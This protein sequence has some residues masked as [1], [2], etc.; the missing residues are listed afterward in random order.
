MFRIGGLQRRANARMASSMGGSSSGGFTG[1]S[2]G[3]GSGGTPG[4]GRGGTTT[5]YN[6]VYDDLSEGSIIEYFL[7]VDPRRLHRIWRRIYLQDAIAGP[8]IDLIGE[9]GWSNWEITG[10]QDP[11]IRK[12]YEDCYNAIGA[13]A[14]MPELTKEFLVMGKYIAHLLYD[15][16]KGY[17]TR[18]I[19]QD[20]D[21]LNITKS[22]VAGFPPKIDLIPTPEMR[23]WVTSQDPRD[24]EARDQ[25]GDYAEFLSTG[26]T[27]PLDPA[28]TIYVCR[29][30]APYD[31]IGAS[32][33][34]RIITFVAYEK[35]LVNS[36]IAAA[37]R[38]A[39][40]IRHLVAGID[41]Q[42]GWEPSPEELDS[43]ANLFMRADEDPVGA[44]VVTRTG[45]SV[46]EVGGNSPQDMVKISDE[47]GFISSGKMNALGVSEQFLSGE[48]TYCLSGDTLVPTVERGLVRIDELASKEAGAEQS[49]D[50]TVDSRWGHAKPKTWLYNGTKPTI[51]V[52]T[53]FGNS[54]TG[55]APHK[56]LVF[57]EGDLIWK[58]TKDLQIGDYLC[59]ST[60]KTVRTTP[61]QLSLGDIPHVV[62]PHGIAKTVTKPT[63][64]T[65]D[66]AFAM[67]LIV[68]EGWLDST[69]RISV[70]NA[71]TA[72]LDKYEQILQSTFGLDSRR[73]VVA[74]AGT[75]RVV[76]GVAYN[77]NKTC[78]TSYASSIRVHKW[79]LELGVS[80]EKSQKKEIP[81]SILQADEQSQL[82]FLAAFLEGDGSIAKN[83]GE[84]LF[85]S[86]SKKILA[87]IQSMLNAHGFV[88]NN[89][90]VKTV[91][92][93]KKDSYE[94]YDRLKPYMVT[95]TQPRFNVK[96]RNKFGVPNEW[97]KA[98][99]SERKQF[100][101]RHGIV[102]R[103]DAGEDTQ[104][105]GWQFPHAEK[106]FL[107]DRLDAG[108]Y[109]F[110]DQLKEISK[111]THEKLV[112]LF[113]LRYNFAR[114]TK[115]EEGPVTD[116]YDLSMEDTENRSFVANGLI[117]S[118]STMEQLMSV[119][120]EKIR[121]LRAG[122]TVW[123]LDEVAKR[124]A[125]KNE[126]VKRTP[127]QLKH[128]IRIKK[129]AWELDDSELILPTF[130]YAKN[131]R[132]VAD[133]DY[134]E[135]LATLEEKGLPVTL[136]TWAATAGFEL[137]EE[138]DQYKEDVKLR[139]VISEY[140]TQ[141]DSVDTGG[142]SGG[143][144]EGGGDEGGDIEDLLGEG[145]GSPLRASSFLEPMLDTVRKMPIWKLGSFLGLS[146][147]Q[148][149]DAVRKLGPLMNG[150]DRVDIDRFKAAS[151]VETGNPRRNQV[152]TY[153]MTRAGILH[154]Q[155]I[156][157]DTA[158]DIAKELCNLGVA[159]LVDELAYV[160]ACT[161]LSSKAMPQTERKAKV[162]SMNKRIPQAPLND[163]KLLYSG[164]AVEP[165]VREA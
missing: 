76:N 12:L 141:L 133:K 124:L 60:N 109:S 53:E 111:A 104:L 21:Y 17:F 35:A 128:G 96:A 67:G 6:P 61:L 158:E 5:R 102:F 129:A 113:E 54:F 89:S 16:S 79:L 23:S 142:T 58:E 155:K 44:I 59:L 40:K 156:S 120:L 37:K 123:F 52:T 38:R 22:P 152:L 127:A 144:D 7:P 29:K 125:R 160:Q 71:D 139:K 25:L 154:G 90:I 87:S 136:R 34:T 93:G 140:K 83:T 162:I 65:P 69:G 86:S 74:E 91:S 73:H 143:D 105:R 48:S 32:V 135:I 98:V 149:L 26:Q 95:K 62:G 85:V 92:L 118:N 130:A 30:T 146:K 81:W 131:L 78:Y 145:E 2:A 9:M 55:T 150:G 33:F 126:F 164:V 148:A 157:K 103:N 151:L 114:I 43:Y 41:G 11:S 153:V 18:C 94:L 66:I 112:K 51:K 28:N 57:Q 72:L 39:G 13:V 99:I 84:I 122:Q 15:D 77:C 88:C 31:S 4:M 116:V 82:S 159:N 119:F 161:F 107:Y 68:A 42:E 19:V 8:A 106:R 56:M 63:T 108:Q 47:W 64:M 165:E 70:S 80:P 49:L 134:L 36:T 97:V 27:I 137:N 132:P 14:L 100:H 50:I 121:S 10:V 45:V 24:I 110:L 101:N 147:D 117:S 163:S 3:F 46:N 138:L 75:S 115:I 20:P 1:G